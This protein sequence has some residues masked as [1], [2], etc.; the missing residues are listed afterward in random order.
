MR[1]YLKDYNLKDYNIK[2][3]NKDNLIGEREIF[4]KEIYSEEGIYKAEGN[5]V[6]KLDIKDKK[7]EYLEYNK[8]NLILDRSE[9]RW[10]P[11]YF[12]IP[13]LHVIINFIRKEY[14]LERNSKLGLNVIYREGKVED[15]YFLIKENNFNEDLKGE[16]M[17]FL[18]LLIDFK[19]Y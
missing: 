13:N 18:S 17:N 4:Y 7:A 15:I 6:Y 5:M 16:I 19:K 10:L 8:F 9:L 12:H 2:N 14:K 3:L 1:I 11:E